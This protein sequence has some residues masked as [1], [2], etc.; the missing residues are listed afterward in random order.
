MKYGIIGCGKMGS[1]IL[2]SVLTLLSK[3][4]NNVMVS[5]ID[6]NQ[7]NFIKKTFGVKTTSS[8]I[9]LTKFADIIILAVKPQQIS[10][11]LLE[12]KDFVDTKKFLISIAAGIKLSFIEKVLGKKIAVVRCMPNLPLKY[13]FGLTSFCVNKNVSLAQKKFVITLFSSHGKV[14]EV[15]ENMMDSITAI[16]GSGPAYIFYISE[17]M[18]KVAKKFGFNTEISKLLVNQTILGAAQMLNLSPY[19]AKKLK[20]DVTSKGGTTQQALEIFYKHNLEKI[21]FDAIT[22]AKCRAK[23]LANILNKN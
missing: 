10:D 6:K 12:I 16:S 19:E 20:E 3:K 1:V 13:G 4:S 22:S 14:I 15:K 18:Q 17:I 9:E 21:F 5:E 11:V 7:L 2:E 8:N 23:E